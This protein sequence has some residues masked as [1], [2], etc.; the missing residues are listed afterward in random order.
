MRY[1]EVT[2]IQV[3]PSEVYRAEKYPAPGFYLVGGQLFCVS[4]GMAMMIN[5]PVGAIKDMATPAGPGAAAGIDSAT[6]LKALA[7]AQEPRLAIELAK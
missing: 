1:I 5:M 3:S 2:E 6:F 7:I 4:G